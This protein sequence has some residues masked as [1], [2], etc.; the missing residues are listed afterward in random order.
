MATLNRENKHVD[1]VE[2]SGRTRT[3]QRPVV[4]AIIVAWVVLLIFIA[5]L[6]R[7]SRGPVV[8]PD[9]M[10]RNIFLGEAFSLQHAPASSI[11]VH[12]NVPLRVEDGGLAILDAIGREQSFIQYP[13]RHPNLYDAGEALIIAPRNDTEIMILL[14]DLTMHELSVE[15]II[16]GGDYR[17]GYVLLLGQATNNVSRVS[18]HTLTQEAPLLTL[19][20][21][22]HG[23]PIR[24]S[25]AM[26]G[27]YFDVLLVDFS[28]GTPVTRVRRFDFQGELIADRRYSNFGFLPAILQLHD[29]E[30][31]LFGECEIVAVNTE[32]GE[33]R[34]SRSF[35]RI[36]QIDLRSGCL[37][38]RAMDDGRMS[39]WFLRGIP[40]RVEQT[41]VKA[42]STEEVIDFALSGDGVYALGVTADKLMLFNTMTGELIAERDG[43]NGMVRVFAIA[44]R[45]YL[46]LTKEEGAIVAIR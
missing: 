8:L 39:M 45:N 38:I 46:V 24:V 44:N 30:Q 33:L 9:D 29:K 27:R 34:L 23:R 19:S 37:G 31:V 28:E 3:F 21:S 1:V 25:F 2:S 20:I 35:D 15:A 11:R 4:A 13:Y 16:Q 26:S 5:V 42:Q 6:T 43:L 22:E 41:L 12:A 32:T 14:P 36:E 7:I 40:D 10:G 17:D 18:L